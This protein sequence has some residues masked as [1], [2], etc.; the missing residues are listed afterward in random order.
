MI[1]APNFVAL[2]DVCERSLQVKLLCL[3]MYVAATTLQIVFVY[4]CSIAKFSS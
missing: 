4:F 2:L 1:F 3:I